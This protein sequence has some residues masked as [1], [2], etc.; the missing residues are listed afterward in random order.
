M[1][2]V[3]QTETSAETP[4]PETVPL[5]DIDQAQINEWMDDKIGP[6]ETEVEEVEESKESQA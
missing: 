5:S 6:V 3:E 4:E 2:E 1:E